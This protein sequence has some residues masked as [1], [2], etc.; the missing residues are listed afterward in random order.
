M[1][2]LRVLGTVSFW[3]VRS[4]HCEECLKVKATPP[5]PQ[6]DAELVM[7]QTDASHAAAVKALE[8]NNGDIVNAIMD[9][10]P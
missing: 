4:K 9:L 10:C 3:Q 8:A 6:S 5:P 7:S 2:T 1:H